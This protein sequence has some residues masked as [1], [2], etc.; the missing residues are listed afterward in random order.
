MKK[1]ALIATYFGELPFWFPAFQLSCKYNPEITWIIFTDSPKQKDCPDN[2]IFKKLSLYEFCKIASAKIGTKIN[3]SEKFLYK[4]CD[5]KPAFGLIYE[6]YIQGYDFWGHCDLDVVFGRVGNFITN[7]IL[8]KYDIITSRKRRI[9][10]H[11]CLYRNTKE[12][13]SIFL[14]IPCLIKLL[15]DCGN[16]QRIDEE[17]FSVYL[18]KL[19]SPS[20]LSRIKVIFIKRYVP[21]I[22]WDKSLTTSGKCQRCLISNGNKSFRWSKGKVYDHEENEL[23]YIHFHILKRL[24]SFK[25]CSIRNDEGDIFIS[26]SGIEV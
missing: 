7:E 1:K 10:G 14:H 22:Y 25:N 5:F 3:L 6:D 23:M 15:K 18:N 26:P 21:R 12:I 17:L 11:F 13:N 4:I 20:F 8:E 19:V 24:D 16:Y 2:L 9:S